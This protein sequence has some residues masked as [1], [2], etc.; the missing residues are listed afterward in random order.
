M[1]LYWKLIRPS[2]MVAIFYPKSKHPSALRISAGD[3][4][5]R[6]IS[7]ADSRA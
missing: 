3:A 1:P 2:W 4:F 6:G 5:S 7:R